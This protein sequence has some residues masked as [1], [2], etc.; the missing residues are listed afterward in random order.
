MWDTIYRRFFLSNWLRSY[1]SWTMQSGFN[2]K[3]LA[4]QFQGLRNN[5]QNL[6]NEE[7][8]WRLQCR[9][10]ELEWM[11]ARMDWRQSFLW[12]SQE[13]R[14]RETYWYDTK[15]RWRFPH[16]CVG[17]CVHAQLMQNAP[18]SNAIYA[19]HTTTP[20]SP[21]PPPPFLPTSPYSNPQLLLPSPCHSLSPSCGVIYERR[22]H[23]WE[24]V[25]K[26]STA[27]SFR[28]IFWVSMETSKATQM[29]S[30]ISQENFYSIIFVLSSSKNCPSLS[31]SLLIFIDKPWWINCP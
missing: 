13:S 25:S 29:T 11:D 1:I 16:D 3:L 7:L 2:L 24:Q 12:R 30:R 5:V 20:L 15:V 9:M 4:G 17:Y 28:L 21:P 14:C 18:H 19:S 23:I 22:D 10:G 26:P 8:K 27:A 6:R 31:R